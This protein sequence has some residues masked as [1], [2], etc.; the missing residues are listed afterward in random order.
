MC[1]NCNNEISSKRPG[2]TPRKWLWEFT[3][4]AQCSV[5]GTCLDHKDLLKISRRLGLEIE[6]DTRDYDLHGF[7]VNA[8]SEDS[9][10]S[11]SIHKFLDQRYKGPLRRFL[12][13][14]NADQINA[15]WDEMK[16]SGKIA[17]A[18]YAV[19]TLSHIPLEV[20]STIFGEIHMLSHL[21]GASYRQQSMQTA[22]LQTQLD[23]LQQ[24][25]TR[26]EAG[27]RESLSTRDTQ[28]A[29]LEGKVTHLRALDAQ[30]EQTAIIPVA[31]VSVDNS[32]K[33][34]RAVEA[35]RERAYEAEAK[36]A[37]MNQQLVALQQ[38]NS[39]LQAEIRNAVSNIE[40]AEKAVQLNGLS[41]LYI[42]GRDKQ[43]SHF[44]KL[45]EEAGGS[46]VHHDGGLEDAVKRI[47]EVLPTVDCVLCPINC[48]S[49]DACLRAKSGCKK[50]GKQFV[51]MRSA[52]KTSL[53][54]AF[55][56]IDIPNS[57]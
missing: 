17:G 52:S 37:S 41:F 42:G 21:I 54:N 24:R 36:M 50:Y 9:K 49:H 51:P 26:V 16:E 11:R 4:N 27:L 1:A 14:E 40:P 13:L 35:A 57:N 46:L 20:R 25:S 53:L 2:K 7:F 55:H 43:I 3:D 6:S 47:D 32:G 39:R 44:R 12:R 34:K 48:V 28:I 18:Y 23:T 19:M 56:E 8:T 29:E 38:Q 22:N 31:K 30:R 15:L 10:T 45:A 5:L 33:S